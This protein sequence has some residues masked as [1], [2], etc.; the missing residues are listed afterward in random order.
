MRDGPL[1]KVN[2]RYVY[3]FVRLALLR[4]SGAETCLQNRLIVGAEGSSMSFKQVRLAA[5]VVG[6]LLC[7]LLRPALAE[8]ERSTT[9]AFTNANVIP[10]D[11]NGVGQGWTVLVRDDRIVE[12]GDRSEIKVP[13]NAVTIDCAG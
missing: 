12:V 13:P 1:A 9:V 4:R 10:L 3:L 8:R 11:H 6:A 5:L 2:T 7:V